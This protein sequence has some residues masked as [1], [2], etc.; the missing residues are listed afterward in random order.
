M[1]K[2]D[3]IGG[4]NRSFDRV[5]LLLDFIIIL[6]F[7]VL[8]IFNIN[9]IYFLLI[10]IVV[11]AFHFLLI[12]RRHYF[13]IEVDCFV[14]E[15]VF[16]KELLIKKSLYKS[17]SSSL[18]SIPFTNE[19]RIHFNDGRDFIFLGGVSKKGDLEFLIKRFVESPS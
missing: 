15:H 7:L 12:V 5:K 14:V 9:W 6:F 19:F 18:I 8:S 4:G 11:T 2:M 10:Y 3:R 1:N 16:K 13:S 17:I